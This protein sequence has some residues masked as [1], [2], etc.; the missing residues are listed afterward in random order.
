MR[1]LFRIC[2]IAL[3][4]SAAL[5][6]LAYAQINRF[7]GTYAGLPTT[8]SGESRCPQMETP[9]PLTIA[10]G[11]AQTAAGNFTGTVSA[12]G[13]VVMHAQGIRFEGQIDATGLV[14]IVGGSTHGCVY[15]YS[16]KKR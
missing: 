1:R 9:S 2:L 16:W 15:T 14:K 11:N 4:M 12:D 10:N 5:P 3:A 6:V 13:H 8:T 7:D